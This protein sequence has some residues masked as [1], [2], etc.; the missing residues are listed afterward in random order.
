MPAGKKSRP[1][2]EPI[3]DGVYLPEFSPTVQPRQTKA[4]EKEMTSR[5]GVGALSS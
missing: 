2:P 5:L 3:S 1:S 4:G